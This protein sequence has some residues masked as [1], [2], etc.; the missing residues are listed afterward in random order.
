MSNLSWEEGDDGNIWISDLLSGCAIAVCRE[1]DGNWFAAEDNSFFEE[2]GPFKDLKT[3][4]EHIEVN[5]LF[6]VWGSPAN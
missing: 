5:K 4:C 1:K 2:I 6:G 3:L